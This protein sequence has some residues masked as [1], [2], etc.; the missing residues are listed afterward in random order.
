MKSEEGRRKGSDR[1]LLYWRSGN[2]HDAFTVVSL[3]DLQFLMPVDS[4]SIRRIF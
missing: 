1:T 2:V 3:L 4:W